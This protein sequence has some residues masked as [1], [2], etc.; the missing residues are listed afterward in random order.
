[1]EWKAWVEY[2]SYEG[3]KLPIFAYFRPN[4]VSRFYLYVITLTTF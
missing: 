1:L 4:F 2:S 3:A